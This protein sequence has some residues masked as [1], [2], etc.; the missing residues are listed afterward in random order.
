MRKRKNLKNLLK[1]PK[2]LKNNYKD[3]ICPDWLSNLYKN[4]NIEKNKDNIT[5]KKF[6][7]KK[8]KKEDN[9]DE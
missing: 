5:N 4:K 9:K 6:I 7:G 8:R 2:N 1:N 3:I